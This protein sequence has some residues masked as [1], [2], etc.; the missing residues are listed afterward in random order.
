MAHY[1]E[2]QVPG[3]PSREHELSL[4]AVKV[5][6]GSEAELRLPVSSGF[7]GLQLELT[8]A[9]H[10]VRVAL[11]SGAQGTL[12]FR[13]QECAEAFVPW[14]EELFAGGVRLAF[15][16]RPKRAGSPLL[17]LAPVLLLAAG[18][19]LLP[20]LENR[21][22]GEGEVEAPPLALSKIECREKEPAHVERRAR[23]AEH[24]GRAKLQ[25]FAF[26]AHEGIEA[27]DLLAEASACFNAA[28]QADDAA[29]A[30]DAHSAWSGQLADD[31]AAARLE[32]RVALEQ[33]RYQQALNA[34]SHL[35]A[36]L[37]ARPACP[38]SE[39]LSSVAHRLERK[40]AK[41]GS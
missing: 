2:I 40:V 22:E 37:A 38:Y 6:T 19:M 39:W 14:N 33:E 15:I 11:F 4:R 23:E 25:R 10:G 17:L 27:L 36:L 32:L 35:Q 24:A 3:L 21:V 5:G 1:V 26:A 28:G 13:G 34:A 31:Y 8:T 7:A 29:R 16:A 18:M 30:R 41:G 12:V 20:K 9:E